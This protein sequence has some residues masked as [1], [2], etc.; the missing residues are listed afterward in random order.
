MIIGGIGGMLTNF[1]G[2]DLY[3]GGLRP[4]GSQVITNWVVNETA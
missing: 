3:L 2:H 1:A 4:S